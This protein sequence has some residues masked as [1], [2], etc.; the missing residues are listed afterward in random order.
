MTPEEINYYNLIKSNNPKFAKMSIEKIAE[1]L[2]RIMDAEE[3]NPIS[4]CKATD[5]LAE[6]CW[7]LS[8]F[9]FGVLV[10]KYLL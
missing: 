9:A 7:I 3:S 8:I 1:H 10:G 2:N 6:F 5:L 4:C